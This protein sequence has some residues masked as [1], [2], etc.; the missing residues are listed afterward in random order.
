MIAF[1]AFVQLLIFY[2]GTYHMSIAQYFAV[3]D[4]P[5]IPENHRVEFYY[6]ESCLPHNVPSNIR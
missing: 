1:F 4:L 2:A 6:L 5:I 3:A